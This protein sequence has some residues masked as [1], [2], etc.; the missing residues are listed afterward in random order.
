MFSFSKTDVEALGSQVVSLDINSDSEKTLVEQV[1]RN[2]MDCL[3]DEDRKLPQVS[4]SPS[5]LQILRSFLVRGRLMGGEQE[6]M[7]ES[8]RKRPW[9]KK[10]T[11]CEGGA[12]P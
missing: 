7:E 6:S 10:A 9:G 11:R 12:E 4:R 1:F 2:A 3:G 5:C 8:F